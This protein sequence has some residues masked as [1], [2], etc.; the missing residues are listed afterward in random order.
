[1]E[2]ISNKVINESPAAVMNVEETT[3]EN[4]SLSSSPSGSLS[5][6]IS[7][8]FTNDLSASLA[9]TAPIDTS[10]GGRGQE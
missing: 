2:V 8:S 3:P 5:G 4:S 1:M 10:T 9:T 7:G 6:S